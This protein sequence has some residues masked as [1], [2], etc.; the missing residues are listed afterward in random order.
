MGK[1][2]DSL[3]NYLLKLYWKETWK[4]KKL[5]ELYQ[6]YLAVSADYEAQA[7]L[8]FNQKDTREKITRLL[9]AE[10][11]S[12]DW[13]K[14]KKKLKEQDDEIEKTEQRIEKIQEKEEHIRRLML[15]IEKI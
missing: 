6:T 4:R 15:A 5:K 3:I 8:L 2:I 7:E 10:I 12:D 11:K 14:L 9:D 13:L 1:I